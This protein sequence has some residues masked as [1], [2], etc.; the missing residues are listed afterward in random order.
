M[1]SKYP[2]TPDG[3]Y[4][5]VRSRLWRL[6]NP[7]LEPEARSKFVAGLMKARRDVR[8]A[9]KSDDANLLKKARTA[10]HRAKVELGERGPVWWDCGSPD[11]N[12]YLVK[13]T[14]YA[15]WY[16]ALACK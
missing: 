7:G 15:R 6:S 16:N 1:R 10:V 4:F 9:L 14:P 11:Y 2:Q 3:H 5:I 13:N 12:R 8:A